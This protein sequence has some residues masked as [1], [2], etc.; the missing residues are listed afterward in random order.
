MYTAII[1]DY[2]TGKDLTTFKVKRMERPSDLLTELSRRQSE[3]DVLD[4][5]LM[6]LVCDMGIT[7]W[8][9]KGN[10]Y[11][12]LDAGSTRSQKQPEPVKILQDGKR[13]ESNR[14]IGFVV[15]PEGYVLNTG[16][17]TVSV[18]GYTSAVY[19]DFIGR[20][21]VHS[22]GKSN[23]HVFPSLKNLSDYIH[24]HEATLRILVSK[25]GYQFSVEHANDLYKREV[26]QLPDKKKVS[27]S[28]KMDE[29][30]NFLEDIN[31]TVE[32][33]AEDSPLPEN[34]TQNDIFD[35]SD[36]RMKALNLWDR[37]VLDYRQTGKVFQ[38]EVGGIIYDLDDNAKAA[39]KKAE[40]MGFLPYHV[41]VS[42]TTVGAM[43]TVLYASKN[44]EE[45]SLERPDKD[46][47]LTAYIY[48]AD[49][50]EFS[51]LGSIQVQPA[52]GG[53]VRLQ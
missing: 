8:Y 47:W 1:R 53:L 30:E 23:C 12:S 21:N 7:S 3:E 34:P 11:D 24:R 31:A 44:T 43:Y 20:A 49:C 4:V 40:D 42:H 51:E 10:V 35:E 46:G 28:E 17:T 41:I 16:K 22:C 36:R 32:E 18:L 25:H 2:E 50:P 19:L 52:N 15:Y 37:V 9:K 39:V 38:S 45:W 48:N 13:V 27:L 26:E 5:G 14:R 6:G 29:I 33:D